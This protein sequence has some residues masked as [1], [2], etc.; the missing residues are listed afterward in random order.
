MLAK[1]ARIGCAIHDAG[2][3][4]RG[5]VASGAGLRP[6]DRSGRTRIGSGQY[7]DLLD[8][9][10]LSLPTEDL[11]ALVRLPAL[12]RAVTSTHR[13]QSATLQPLRRGG[14]S[15]QNAPNFVIWNPRFTSP[16]CSLAR[17]GHKS[18]VGSDENNRCKLTI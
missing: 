4:S 13:Q 11:P 9:L 7:G 5:L 1:E 6:L 3:R 14:P 16:N 10:S 8:D 2:Y 12:H 17:P 15:N 18:L